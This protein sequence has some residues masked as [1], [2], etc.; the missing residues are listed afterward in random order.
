MAY[1]RNE[2]Y[3]NAKGEMK[4]LKR[5]VIQKH[6]ERLPG[7]LSHKDQCTGI[8]HPWNTLSCLRMVHCTVCLA[9][10]KH[11]SWWTLVL[12]RG[13]E[14]HPHRVSLVRT[15][16]WKTQCI[17]PSLT[18]NEG[19]AEVSASTQQ[20]VP[21]LIQRT[22]VETQRGASHR[23]T[24]AKTTNPSVNSRQIA[25]AMQ[26]H[27]LCQFLLPHPAEL[28]HQSLMFIWSLWSFNY[29][30]IPPWRNSVTYDWLLLLLAHSIV[31]PGIDKSLQG[32]SYCLVPKFWTETWGNEL[33]MIL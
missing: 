17:K 9:S 18:L 5:K 21:S 12:S 8:T 22:P 31:L 27:Q 7:H 10:K 14:W 26:Q 23:L 13:S 3:R 6:Q 15:P 1:S 11:F 24:H 16:Q 19:L 2:E 32:Q 4:I 25:D 30:Y 33:N 29:I 20:H 28:T